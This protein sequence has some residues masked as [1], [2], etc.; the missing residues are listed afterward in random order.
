MEINDLL[1]DKDALKQLIGALQN[2]VDQAPNDIDQE[3][4]SESIDEREDIMNTKSRKKV[5]STNSKKSG[6]KNN[7]FVNRFDGMMEKN[8]HKEDI[9]IDKLLKK[10]PKTPRTRKANMIDVVCRVCGTKENI[11]SSL[12]T[13]SKDRY[14]CNSC[15]TRAG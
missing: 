7:N 15:S 10:H 14:K 8:M 13:D 2:L 12:L 4:V 6:K 11:P 1:K 5:Y 9:E 3:T